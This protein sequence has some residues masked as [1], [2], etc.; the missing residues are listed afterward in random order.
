MIRLSGS[1]EAVIWPGEEERLFYQHLTLSDF[2]KMLETGKVRLDG[3][4]GDNDELDIIWKRRNSMHE[5]I[6]AVRYKLKAFSDMGFHSIALAKATG[7]G[8]PGF[9][10]MLS[11][12]ATTLWE[13]WWR[14]ENV[15]SRNHPMLGAVAE[16]LVSSVAGVSLAPTAIGGKQLL[17]WPRIPTSAVIVQHASNAR[18]QKRRCLRSM[19]V[20]G[21]SRG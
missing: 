15:F 7:E 18:H 12:N 14:S 3:T 11:H 4:N 6:L 10:Y 19:G 5:G 17:F 21:S 16:W 1:D 2:K 13:S 8:F 20:S 9:E